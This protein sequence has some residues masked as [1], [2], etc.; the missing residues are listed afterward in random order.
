VRLHVTKFSNSNRREPVALDNHL[1]SIYFWQLEA[2]MSYYAQCNAQSTNATT[3]ASMTGLTLT[4]PEGVGE[5]AIITLNVRCH[6]Q[7]ATTIQ[8]E[9]SVSR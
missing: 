2:D 6:T 5:T 4:I 3:W 9:C 7:R 1:L 8:V